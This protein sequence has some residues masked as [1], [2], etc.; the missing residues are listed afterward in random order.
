MQS[1][2]RQCYFF[3]I[4]P[5]T[6]IYDIALKEKDEDRERNFEK[7]EKL[8]K[9]LKEK[10]QKIFTFDD[11]L[12]LKPLT[13]EYYDLYI[14]NRAQYMHDNFYENPKNSLYLWQ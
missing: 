6:R 8:I 7:I 9:E 5:K 4:A 3:S 2:R 13:E 12:L 1:H 11:I 14:K 10:K